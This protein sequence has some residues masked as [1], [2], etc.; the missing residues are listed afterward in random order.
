M[1]QFGMSLLCEYMTL[2]VELGRREGHGNREKEKNFK[3]LGDP[4]NRGNPERKANPH[5]RSH[6]F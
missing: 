4:T 1:N 3:P 5:P 2:M 6:V